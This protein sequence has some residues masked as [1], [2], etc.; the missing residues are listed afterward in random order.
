MRIVKKKKEKRKK[1]ERIRD[2]KR[3]SQNQKTTGNGRAAPRR[4]PSPPW[5][6]RLMDPGEAVS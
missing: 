3:E 4:P 5:K 2:R 6:H 1:R